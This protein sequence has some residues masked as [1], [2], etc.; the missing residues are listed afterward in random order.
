MAE[1]ISYFNLYLG[2]IS[3]ICLL[4]I[5]Q[6]PEIFYGSF[7]HIFHLCMMVTS[8]AVNL[9]TNA[10]LAIVEYISPR[11]LFIDLIAKINLHYYLF[12]SPLPI[13]VFFFLGE[14][15]SIYIILLLLDR[16]SEF[17]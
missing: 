5:I 6:R 12:F 8:F 3:Y 11:P 13:I 7:F 10:S 4:Q 17:Y 9:F 16:L 15:I 1:Y 14:N 2:N